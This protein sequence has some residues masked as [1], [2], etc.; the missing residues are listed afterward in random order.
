MSR[1]QL[2]VVENPFDGAERALGALTER[3]HGAEARAANATPDQKLRQDQT[4]FDG[5]AQAD[6]IG[7]EERDA[8]HRQRLEQGHEL[9]VVDLGRRRRRAVRG[10]VGASG[11]PG[12]SAFG[13]RNGAPQRVARTSASGFL[14]RAWGRPRPRGA[15]RW[16]RGPARRALAPRRASPRGAF[17]V[18]VLDANEVHAI[19]L[20]RRTRL[21]GGD[22][23][24]TVPDRGEHADTGSGGQGW[25]WRTSTTSRRGRIGGTLGGR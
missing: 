24:L 8:G 1:P 23:P 19:M 22:E 7:Q 12:S 13:G 17:G 5:L 16:A 14:R 4:R 6:I 21:H 9:E 11:A 2:A 20:R 15:A 18:E 3:L 25:R 10:W